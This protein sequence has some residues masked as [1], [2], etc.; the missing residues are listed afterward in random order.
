[1]T[2]TWQRPHSARP[3]H[4]ESTSTPRVRAACNRGVP[5]RE[6]PALAGGREDDECVLLAHAGL[7]APAVSALAP[8][9]RRAFRGAAA[10][11]PAA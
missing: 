4:T 11:P 3:P 5:T 7:G 1:M 8:A 2:S 10:A 6:A 9:A